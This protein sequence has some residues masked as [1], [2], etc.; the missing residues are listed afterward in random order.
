MCATQEEAIRR[1]TEILT[2]D[3]GGELRIHGTDG[4]VRDQRTIAPATTLTLRQA[5]PVS[6][7]GSAVTRV[8]TRRRPHGEAGTDA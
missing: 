1:A 3:G 6:T 7:C 2:A 8:A 5:D 4:K